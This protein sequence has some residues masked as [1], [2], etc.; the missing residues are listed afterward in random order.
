M[1]RRFSVAAAIVLVSILALGMQT[2]LVARTGFVMGDFRAFYCAARVAMHGADPYRA[3]PLGAC[4]RSSEPRIFREK[5]F[6]VIV[7][8]PLPGYAI[9]AL[10]PLALLPFAAAAAIWAVLLFLGWLAS[11]AA[12]VRCA[13]VPWQTALAA[14]VLSLGAASLPF[15][16]IVPLA[17]AAICISGYFA[18]R[19]RWVAAA[20]AA[21][22]AMIEPHIG[23][24][25]C[26]ALVYWAPATRMTLGLSL[27]ALG[28]LS[29]ATLG[30]A[31]NLEYFASVLPAH[32]LSE[33]ARDTQFSL[34]SMLASLG[35]NDTA[36]VRAGSLWYLAM[37]VVGA[38]VAGALAKRLNDAAFLV[39]V[40]PAFAVFGGTF[41]HVTQIAAAIPA[42][43]LLVGHLND[44]RRAVAVAALLLLAVPWIMAWSPSLGLAPAFP[45]GYLAWRYSNQNVRAVL[46][47]ALLSGVLLVGLNRATVVL[48]AA[49]GTSAPAYSGATIDPAFA[50]ASWAEFTRK[51]STGS[52]AAWLVRIPTWG[53]LAVLLVLLTSAS[54]AIPARKS[55]LNGATS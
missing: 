12:L 2:A 1:V 53:S 24:P 41:I 14:L 45:I 21:A 11:V 37:L 31:T 38:V 35:V 32:A 19:G 26:I 15:G 40:P 36:A 44:R 39:F 28:L 10:A 16:E 17:I 3:E 18:W 27:A 49:R 30:L 46:A 50:E 8:A 13:R 34:T 47:A 5:N 22:A 55:V 25:V 43:L 9:G 4:E 23:L 52:A 33:A 51:S 6:R 7:P 48:G 20:L 29:L 42:A 54:G